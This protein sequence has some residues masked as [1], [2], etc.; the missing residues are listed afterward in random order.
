MENQE[1]GLQ[2]AIT[3]NNNAPM[4]HAGAIMIPSVEALGKL[5]NAETGVSLNLKYKK[6][7]DWEAE[8]ANEGTTRAYYLGLKNLPNEDGE[9]LL[10][11]VFAD[12]NGS[13]LAAQTVIIDAVRNLEA[14]TP[15]QITYK[16]SKKNKSTKGSTHLFDIRVLRIKVEGGSNG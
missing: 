13:F 15:V 2:K 10:C 3:E 1:T 16:G 5:E 11:A 7:E 4:F 9:F 12:K 8:A 6:V 14:N